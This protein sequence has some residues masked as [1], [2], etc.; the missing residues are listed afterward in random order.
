MIFTLV[1]QRCRPDERYPEGFL[2]DD[3]ARMRARRD[4]LI[5]DGCSPSEIITNARGTMFHCQA[6]GAI[7]VEING[8][9]RG[10]PSVRAA[11]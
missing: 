11:G 10:L 9:A 3:E 8:R 7:L 1:L 6:P 5:A 4:A 2:V